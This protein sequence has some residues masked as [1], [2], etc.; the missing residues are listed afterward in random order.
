MTIEPTSESTSE[1]HDLARSAAT[2]GVPRYVMIGGFLGAGKTTAVA[3]FA[4]ALTDQGRRVG[5]ITNDQSRGLVDTTMLRKR[6]FA[7]EEIEGGCF[8]CRFPSLQEASER[9]SEDA[10]P[11]VFLA[12]PVGSC[13]DLVATVS[14]PLRRIWGDRFAIAPLSVLIDPERLARMY[15]LREGRSFSPKVRY[16]F[17]KQLEEAHALVV[18]KIDDCD[19]SLLKDLLSMLAERYPAARTFAISARDGTGV[20]AWFQYLNTAE[21]PGGTAMHVDYDLYAEGEALLGWVNAT[22]TLTGDRPHDGDDLLVRLAEIVRARLEA[23]G[24]EIAHLKMTLDPGDP[25]G[26]IAA[27]SVIR[28]ETRGELRETLGERIDGGTLMVNLRAEADPKLLLEVLADAIEAGTPIGAILRRE[29]QEG[30]RPG[31][32]VPTHRFTESP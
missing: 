17:E 4:Q 7:V 29:H 9:L 26:A 1:E 31:R 14:Y 15:G 19:P 30:F 18:N 23:A 24:I 16:V 5:L 8:C 21:L 27:I 28:S 22:F 6:G 11:D 3:R 2:A 25:T 32:P 10:R 13:T 12:E 20:D